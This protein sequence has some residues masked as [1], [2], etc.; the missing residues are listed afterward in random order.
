MSSHSYEQDQRTDAD[1]YKAQ[2]LAMGADR[3]NK[4]R[5]QDSS[6]FYGIHKGGEK[7]S[8]EI[9][10]SSTGELSML[11]YHVAPKVSRTLEAPLPECLARLQSILDN[12]ESIKDVAW[13]SHNDTD[14]QDDKSY[15]GWILW[16]AGLVAVCIIA[17]LITGP[18]H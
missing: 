11:S 16:V 3:V 14:E 6:T 1:F 10:D 7:Y 15:P 9:F 8:L 2:I 13:D 4:C 18:K 17:C 5:T 12:P